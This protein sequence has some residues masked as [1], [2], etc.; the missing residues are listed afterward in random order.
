VI[1]DERVPMY[2]IVYSVTSAKAFEWDS[3]LKSY[4]I[5]SKDNLYIAQCSGV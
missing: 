3:V 4:W 2:F 5:K 1:T